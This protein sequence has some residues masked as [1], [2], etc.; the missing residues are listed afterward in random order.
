[1]K[2][3][4]PSIGCHWDMEGS[5]QWP[6]SLLFFLFWFCHQCFVENVVFWGI[7][8]ILHF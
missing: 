5:L 8:R 7:N 6:C 3:K 4:V 2:E 1:M